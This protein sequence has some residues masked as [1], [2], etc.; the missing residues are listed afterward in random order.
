MQISQRL[1]SYQKNDFYE[2]KSKL[3][4]IFS[5]SIIKISNTQQHLVVKKVISRQLGSSSKL[6]GA[7]VRRLKGLSSR[8]YWK[9]REQQHARGFVSCICQA[10]LKKKSSITHR[11]IENTPLMLRHANIFLAE[12]LAT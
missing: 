3:N 7:R 6:S 12:T 1:E 9:L 4:F 2:L 11:E 10:K 5:P 8:S